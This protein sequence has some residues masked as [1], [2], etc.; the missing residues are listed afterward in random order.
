M[1]GAFY[2]LIFAIV[3]ASLSCPMLFADRPAAVSAEANYCSSTGPDMDGGCK[4]LPR[5]SDKEC[6]SNC[7]LC[8]GV[9]AGPARIALYPPGPE[10]GHT[11]YQIS[12]CSRSDRPPVPPPRC[13][14]AV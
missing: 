5:S 2:L 7:A 13:L 12:N 3:S 11:A 9:L 8:L 6:C 1:R 4:Q 14:I 10:A